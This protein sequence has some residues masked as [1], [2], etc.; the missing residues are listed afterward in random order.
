MPE[1]QGDNLS[2]D[3][4]LEQ[5]HGGILSRRL[6]TLLISSPRRR[7]HYRHHPFYG[8]EVEVVR[9]LRRSAEEVLVVKV[10][11]GFQI[12]VPGWMLDAI[13]CSR[14]PQEERQRVALAALLELALRCSSEG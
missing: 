3:S 10:P 8:S 6:P 9:A 7:S 13:H 11:Q 4:T 5:V 2:G 14:L 12:A 1:P